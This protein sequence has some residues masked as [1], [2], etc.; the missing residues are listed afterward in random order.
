M[1]KPKMIIFDCGYTLAYE[2]DVDFLQ[3]MSGSVVT[4]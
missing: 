1:K 4:T 2:H 3:A